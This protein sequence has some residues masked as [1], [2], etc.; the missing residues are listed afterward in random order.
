MTSRS[1]HSLTRLAAS[2]VSIV[3]L[4]TICACGSAPAATPTEQQTSSTKN[5]RVTIFTPSDGITI[6][7]HTPLNKWTKFVPRL[8]SSLGS[9]GIGGKAITQKTS[10]DLEHQSNDV[11]DYVVND[12]ASESDAKE[13]RTIIIAPAFSRAESSRQYGDYASAG[14]QSDAASSEANGKKGGDAG[15]ESK[16]DAKAEQRLAQALRLAQRSGVHTVVLSDEIQGYTPDVFVR[17]STPR[18][19]GIL[20]AQQMV[21]K[22][23]LDKVTSAHP[24]AIEVLLPDSSTAHDP[25]STGNTD[26]NGNDDAQSSGEKTK[27]TQDD[28]FAAQAFAGIWSVLGPYFKDGRAMSPSGLLDKSSD[29]HDWKALT[30]NAQKVPQIREALGKRLQKSSGKDGKD[31]SP[32]AIDGIIAMNDFISAGVV[33]ELD[34]L[35]YQGTSADINPDVSISGLVGT[36]TGRRTLNRQQV[37]KPQDG[38]STD[39]NSADT[40]GKNDDDQASAASGSKAWPIVTGY[41]AYVDMIPHIVDGKQW[42]TGMED[43]QALTRDIS[44]ASVALMGG[45]SVAGV[46]G[47]TKPSGRKGKPYTLHEPLL[48]ISADNL[49]HELIEPGYISMADAGL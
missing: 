10:P 35:K 6:S 28:T 26:A 44:K 11:Q 3:L 21:S 39:S 8:V 22:L 18:G 48:A 12:L 29:E 9:E 15:K 36:I 46:H 27:T 41:G 40:D 30:L 49:K 34:G 43:A 32:A 4:G 20:E 19:I 1:L 7:Q 5:D 31:A 42:M 14:Q 25:D 16:K 38:M 45:K 13:N 37:P 33:E 2:A 23:A 24:K 17:M 47:M